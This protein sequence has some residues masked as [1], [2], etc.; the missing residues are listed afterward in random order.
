MQWFI[1]ETQGR[2][3]QWTDI[4]RDREASVSFMNR[5]LDFG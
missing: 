5:I 2:A 1:Q 3:E 4:F